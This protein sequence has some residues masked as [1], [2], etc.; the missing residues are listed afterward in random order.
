MLNLLEPFERRVRWIYSVLTACICSCRPSRSPTTTGICCSPIQYLTISGRDAH[1]R[2]SRATG[3]AALIDS[4]SALRWDQV[5]SYGSL[6]GDTIYVA[7]VDRNGNA[8]SLI[9]SLYGAFGIVRDGGEYRR[10]PSEPQRLFLAR[11][12]II[13]IASHQEKS[14]CTP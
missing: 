4:S 5:P 2:G 10:D 8:A 7:V 14:R 6:S 3:E 12:S 1:L 13:P 11:S 9:Q